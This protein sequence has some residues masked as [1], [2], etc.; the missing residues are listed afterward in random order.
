MSFCIMESALIHSLDHAQNPNGSVAHSII[1][2]ERY[3]FGPSRK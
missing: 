2:I 1:R 3:H